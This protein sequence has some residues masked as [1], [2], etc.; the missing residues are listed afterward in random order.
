MD[1]EQFRLFM[2]QQSNMITQ[3][4]TTVTQQRP[5]QLPQVQQAQPP[6]SSVP[7]PQPSSL[8][9]EGDMAE[10]F[11][12]FERSWKNYES[13]S[14][15]DKWPVDNNERK[16]SVLLSVIGETA[17]KKYF[18]FELTQQQLADP[19]QAL[20]AIKDKVVVKRNII[21]DRLDF[22][23]ATQFSNELVDDFKTR[24]RIMAKMAKLDTLENELITYKLVTAN[25]WP[26]LRTKML[27]ITDITLDKAVDLCRAE[28]IA[29]RR[30]QEL[31][32]V[33]SS[34]EVNKIS[35]GQPKQKA[36]FAV[37]TTNSL[38]ECA[39]HWGNAVTAERKCAN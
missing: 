36:S 31:G 39:Q 2:E 7:V 23:T 1:P 11:D 4:I 22:F 24:L 18:N 38:K 33:V 6:V 25:K 32:V 21:I 28:E 20:A 13:A 37:I 9:V 16:V 19:D 15:M 29:A 3:L 14:G 26:H 30:S 8:S 10:N 34:S 5:Q 17:R 27:A 35:K 12:F